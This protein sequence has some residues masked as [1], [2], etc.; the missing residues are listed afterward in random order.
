MIACFLIVCV[1][2]QTLI[3]VFHMLQKVEESEAHEKQ[4]ESDVLLY[5]VVKAICKADS[6]VAHLNQIPEDVQYSAPFEIFSPHLVLS[7]L[8]V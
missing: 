5:H 1:Y 2:F 8:L 7:V 4:E 6:E 3:G